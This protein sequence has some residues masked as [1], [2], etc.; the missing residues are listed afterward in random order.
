M[1]RRCDPLNGMSTTVPTFDEPEHEPEPETE[2]PGRCQECGSHVSE[3]FRRVFGDN[4]DTVYSCLECSTRREI[5]DGAG[6]DGEYHTR[7]VAE[8]RKQRGGSPRA[9][10]PGRRSKSPEGL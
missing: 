9:T 3:Q 6:A 1:V 8:T 2:P 5:H 7:A 4:D 10:W